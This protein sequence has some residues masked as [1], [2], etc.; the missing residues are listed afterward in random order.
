[1]QVGRKM[2][3]ERLREERRRLQLSQSELAQAGGVSLSTQVGYETGARVPDLEYLLRVMEAGIDKDY[4]LT[5]ARTGQSRPL[6]LELVVRIFESID[7]WERSRG[8]V[9]SLQKKMDVLRTVY[10]QFH[11]NQ[12]VDQSVMMVAL[13]LAS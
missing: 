10:P 3:G 7:E 4:L 1:M 6:D 13:R 9:L 12:G 11:G 5:G 2:L 8:T